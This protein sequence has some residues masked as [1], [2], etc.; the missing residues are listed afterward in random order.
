M[1]PASIKCFCSLLIIMLLLAGIAPAAICR[2]TPQI[3]EATL[4]SFHPPQRYAKIYATLGVVCKCRDENN[5]EGEQHMSRR[6]AT[7]AAATTTTTTTGSK[8]KKYSCSNLQ[9]LP[10]KKH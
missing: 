4:T 10:W 7:T 3:S 8:K 5:N 6:I 2:Q 1:G 9:C